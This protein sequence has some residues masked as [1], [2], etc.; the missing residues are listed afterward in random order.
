M[1]SPSVLK[2]TPAKAGPINLAALNIEEFKAIAFGKSS[3]SSIKFTI[4][5]WRAVTS[6]AFTK[7]CTS[8]SAAIQNISY[9]LNQIIKARAPAWSIKITCVMTRILY[10]LCL[11]T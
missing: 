8:E 3:L 4:N 9:T 11:S 1:S 2:I 5:D 10:L 7:P 6:K